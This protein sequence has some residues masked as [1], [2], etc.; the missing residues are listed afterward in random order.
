MPTLHT[1]QKRTMI[2]QGPQRC[3]RDPDL[4]TRTWRLGAQRV[5]DPKKSC[6][7][8]TI[9]P[10][11]T[12]T[13]LTRSKECGACCRSSTCRTT[14]SWPTSDAV[15][16]L[17]LVT[18]HRHRSRPW[19]AGTFQVPDRCPEEVVRDALDASGLASVSPD[20]VEMMN[21]H[22]VRPAEHPRDHS[23]GPLLH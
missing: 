15:D 3:L 14:R 9:R 8:F 22:A 1:L 5:I 11:W 7:R 16:R 13:T 12:S 4:Q 23:L 21:S 19:H 18:D 10:T 2:E 20:F 6:A 17:R